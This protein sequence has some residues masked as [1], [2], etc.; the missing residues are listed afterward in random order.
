M[1]C[2]YFIEFIISFNQQHLC[3][4]FE[5][6]TTRMSFISISCSE[7]IYY[8]LLVNLLINFIV[9]LKRFDILLIVYQRTSYDILLAEFMYITIYECILY[10][11]SCINILFPSQYIF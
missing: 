9:L 1:L 3:K 2:I 5:K 6:R 4:L 11:F 7:C 10:M 8:L